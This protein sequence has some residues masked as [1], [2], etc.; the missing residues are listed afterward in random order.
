MAKEEEVDMIIMG[1]G[2]LHDRSAGG[3]IHKFFYGSVTEE[4]IHAAPCS[5][6]VARP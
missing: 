5:V 1:S 4:V 6:F 2:K 3:R